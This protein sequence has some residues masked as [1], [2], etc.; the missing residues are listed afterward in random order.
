MSGSTDEWALTMQVNVLGVVNTLQAFVPAMV[1]HGQPSAVVITASVAGLIS[2]MAGPYG[3]SKHAA[4]A[5][6]EAFH[7]ELASTPGAEHVHL[8]VLCP[9]LVNT[10]LMYIPLPQDPTLD[11]AT[12]GLER[13]APWGVPRYSSNEMTEARDDIDGAIDGTQA[14]QGDSSSAEGVEGF[15]PERWAAAM[16]PEL[17]GRR[18]F[19]GI[20]SGEFYIIV[21]GDSEVAQAGTKAYV[22]TRH[23]GASQ[24]NRL[25]M[26][27]ACGAADC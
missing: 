16:T 9:G 13:V 20:A 26:V 1:A 21:G 15:A 14:R 19:E 5:T 25:V 24:R 27:T 18:V 22:K 7:N 3:V 10:N 2:G 11:P 23:D 17:I 12:F 8:H 4:V 6:A